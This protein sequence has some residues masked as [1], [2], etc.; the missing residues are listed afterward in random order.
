MF[1]VNW[2][3]LR[4]YEQR[5]ALSHACCI[6]IV[7]CL[8]VAGLLY[9]NHCCSYEVVEIPLGVHLQPD[10]YIVLSEDTVYFRPDVL[11]SQMDTNSFAIKITRYRV[12]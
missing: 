10:K 5:R 3:A 1:R 9:L 6:G 2:S 12:R 8:V 11:R 7:L 4:K